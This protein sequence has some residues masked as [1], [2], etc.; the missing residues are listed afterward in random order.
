MPDAR[1]ARAA[2][3]APIRRRPAIAHAALPL[4]ETQTAQG[5]KR[6]RS[7]VG[8]RRG[9]SSAVA[10]AVG[11][12]EDDSA[13]DA[14]LH[15]EL[16]AVARAMVRT[17]QRHEIFGAMATAVCARSNVVNVHEIRLRAAWHLTPMSVTA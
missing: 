12:L 1:L 8:N 2:R 3:F 6:L 13:C 4:T 9:H 17:A 16:T 5:A 11:V 15:D 14:T 10:R 7:D